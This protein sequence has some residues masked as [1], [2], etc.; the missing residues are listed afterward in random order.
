MD[1]SRLVITRMSV[2]VPTLRK[3]RRLVRGDSAM[4]VDSSG[5]RASQSEAGA[6]RVLVRGDAKPGRPSL[7]SKNTAYW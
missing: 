6:L 4:G 2:C 1:A 7:G 5:A 3:V